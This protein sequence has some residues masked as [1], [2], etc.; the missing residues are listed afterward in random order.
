MKLS[1]A[2][3]LGHSEVQRV[4]DAR[5]RS[6][7]PPASLVPKA[8]EKAPTNIHTLSPAGPRPIHVFIKDADFE[9]AV[10]LPRAAAE[11]IRRA[12]S[13]IIKGKA[14]IGGEQTASPTVGTAR[15]A[16]DW[17]M[18]SIWSKF[19][20]FEFQTRTSVSVMAA[21]QL[22][23]SVERH[24]VVQRRHE[25]LG[26]Y[27]GQTSF[28]ALRSGRRVRHF[29][30]LSTLNLVPRKLRR[31]KPLGRRDR[32]TT[33]ALTCGRAEPRRPFAAATGTVL[34][35][36][37]PPEQRTARAST[38]KIDRTRAGWRLVHG[39]LDRAEAL[40]ADSAAAV[41]LPG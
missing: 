36:G 2:T 38:A 12:R 23:W 20:V 6:V 21:A 19:P 9:D 16:L 8:E 15:A 28:A 25:R 17:Q 10:G 22:A 40:H 3:R 33:L 7:H 26:N 32:R 37:R 4:G 39:R 5:G 18:S 1:V 30:E 14:T 41:S 29:A 31:Q 11:E 34:A 35:H 13:P 27:T 24:D